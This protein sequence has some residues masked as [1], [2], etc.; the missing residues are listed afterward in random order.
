M[1]GK[2]SALAAVTRQEAMLETSRYLR[3]LGSSSSSSVSEQGKSTFGCL[4]SEIDAGCMR[5]TGVGE[6]GHVWQVR[7]AMYRLDVIGIFHVFIRAASMLP[8]ARINTIRYSWSI[9]AVSQAPPP[10]RIWVYHLLHL[11]Y[12]DYR[13]GR[14][15]F[16]RAG[17]NGTGAGGGGSLA[18]SCRLERIELPD[19]TPP[20]VSSRCEEN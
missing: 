20:L 4:C 10:P 3:V 2:L 11:S 12:G 16:S 18:L 9:D 1:F 14:S 7:S 8:S 5:R 6:G 13:D 19:S 15:N 17:R